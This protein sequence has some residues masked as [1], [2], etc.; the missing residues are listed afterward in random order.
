MQPLVL[1]PYVS[2]GR[3]AFG[4]SRETSRLAYDWEWSQF[5][6]QPNTPPVESCDK[7]GVHLY[8]SAADKLE[9][10]EVFEPMIEYGGIQFVGRKVRDVLADLAAKG[11]EPEVEDESGY[12]F[13]SIG[14]SHYVS[15]RKIESASA[16]VRGSYAELLTN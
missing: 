5:S 4:A 14:L 16:Y 2:L 8:F 1:V 12:I 11:I 10:V 7:R 15:R 6:K 3:F 9:F 13:E